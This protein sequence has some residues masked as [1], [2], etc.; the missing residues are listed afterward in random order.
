MISWWC[1]FPH[2][3]QI[4]IVG[5]AKEWIASLGL[6]QV[7]FFYLIM[8]QLLRQVEQGQQFVYSV[9]CLELL[10][11]GSMR[12]KCPGQPL[13]DGQAL[14]A[15]LHKKLRNLHIHKSVTTPDL[16]FLIL[17]GV[18][19]H[20]A[21]TKLLR[22]RCGRH[23]ITSPETGKMR[24]GAGYSKSTGQEADL[25]GR[26]HASLVNSHGTSMSRNMHLDGLLQVCKEHMVLTVHWQQLVSRSFS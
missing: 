22:A 3:Q 19:Y 16:Q 2:R 23:V 10:P 6:L 13:H 24:F 11:Y 26:Q 7:P 17:Y 18:T 14:R 8:L 20:Q 9:C 21:S 1:H 5:F 25:K 4:C 15:V 12:N